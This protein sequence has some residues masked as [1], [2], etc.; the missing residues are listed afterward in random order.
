[1]ARSGGEAES[2]PSTEANYCHGHATTGSS[3]NLVALTWFLLGYCEL[4]REY[5]VTNK[6][7]R[8]G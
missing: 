4:R 6:Q 3:D 5:E 2:L 1:M 7:E 8:Q